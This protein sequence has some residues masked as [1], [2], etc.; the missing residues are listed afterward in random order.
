[1]AQYYPLPTD[2]V[3]SLPLGPGGSSVP[4]AISHYALVSSLANGVEALYNTNS[5]TT[6]TSMTTAQSIGA[7]F[8]ALKMTGA[9][10]AG[11][12]LTTDTGPNIIAAMPNPNVGS[13]YQLRIINRSSGNFAWTL[14]ANATGVTVNGTATIAQNTFRDFIM[15]ITSTTAVVFQSVGVGT[16]S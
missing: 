13:S 14:T 2:R 15:T 9:L 12:T 11:G 6:N 16:D 1:M 7:G 10:G 5:A 8:V 4:G 3:V